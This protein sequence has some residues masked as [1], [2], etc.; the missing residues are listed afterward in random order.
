MAI[1]L[2]TYHPSLITPEAFYTQSELFDS[3]PPLCYHHGRSDETP[4]TVFKLLT[5][6]ALR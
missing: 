2:I 6:K 5:Q 1:C 3:P 4:R